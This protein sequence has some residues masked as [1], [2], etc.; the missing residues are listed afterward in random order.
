MHIAINDNA[1]G[2]VDDVVKEVGSGELS[3]PK[4]ASSYSMAETKSVSR[5]LDI[6]LETVNE[7]E[8]A[9]SSYG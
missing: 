9:P 1:L 4:K 7:D 6:R 3:I 5:Y 2:T 8:F